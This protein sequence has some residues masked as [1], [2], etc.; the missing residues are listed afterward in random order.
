LN[1]DTDKQTL[2]TAAEIRETLQAAFRLTLPDAP[3]LDAA[4]T[5]VIAGPA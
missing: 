5:Q 3:G 4:L 2:T 1:G